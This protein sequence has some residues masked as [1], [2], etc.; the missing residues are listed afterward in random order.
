MNMAKQTL[1]DVTQIPHANR[2]AHIF[3][4]FDNLNSEESIVIIND[5][6]PK[7]LYYHLQHE[8]GDCFSWNYL[9][10][11]PETWKVEIT[12][13]ALKPLTIG[14]MA[15]NDFRNAEVFKKLGIDF[16]CGGKKTLEQVCKDNNLDLNTVKAELEKNSQLNSRNAQHDFD[17]WPS[18]FLAD[19][20]VNVHHRYVRDNTQLLDELSEKVARKHGDHFAELPAIRSCVKQLLEELTEHMAKEEQILFPCIKQQEQNDS[21]ESKP[22]CK[23]QSI[24]HPIAVMENDHELAGT[25]LK[26]IRTLTNNYTTPPNACNSFNFLYKKLEEFESDLHQHIHL[27]NNILFVKAQ[28]VEI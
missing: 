22:A 1:I 16:C 15:R 11:G 26:Q 9:E 28:A 5:H 14:E 6:D 7:P 21:N 8:K 19:Y 27:E 4:S 13:K 12:K 10:E 20:I 24:K 18:S 25:L 3:S 23:F 17:S 2:H